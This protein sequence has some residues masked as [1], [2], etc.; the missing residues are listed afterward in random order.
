MANSWIDAE[1]RP[2]DVHG[3][4]WAALFRLD[5]SRLPTVLQPL[6]DALLATGKAA[7]MY[8]WLET[9]YL[10]AGQPAV[11]GDGAKVLM[12]PGAP[13][14]EER[15]EEVPSSEHALE[16]LLRLFASDACKVELPVAGPA[17]SV[18]LLRTVHAQVC[19]STHGQTNL[20]RSSQVP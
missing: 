17:P 7:R 14:S 18:Q 11:D 8:T 6:G 9:H 4:V 19:L 10:H 2:V 5:R 3:D 20:T 16:T 15:P 13:L 12:R 1:N